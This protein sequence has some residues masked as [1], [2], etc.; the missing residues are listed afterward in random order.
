MFDVRGVTVGSARAGAP[1][2]FDEVGGRRGVD[3]LPNSQHQPSLGL[4]GRV[5]AGVTRT[6]QRK[7]V[8]P[9]SSVGP[10]RDGV[11]RAAMPEAA[12]HLDSNAGLGENDIGPAREPAYVHPVAQA[13]AVEFSPEGKF[14]SSASRPQPRH[15]ACDLG[16]GRRRLSAT[17]HRRGH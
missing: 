5:V 3:V 7:L 2:T 1:D 14:R 4:K 12:V 16:R 17:T 10:R 8:S 15:E 6:V 13:S 11:I 9:P